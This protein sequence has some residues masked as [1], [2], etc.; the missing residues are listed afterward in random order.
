MNTADKQRQLEQ[1]NSKSAMLE[2]SALIA[3]ETGDFRNGL[4][5]E[6]RYIDCQRRIYQLEHE[7]QL[8]NHVEAA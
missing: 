8:T 6:R 7:L 2:R 4:Y 1:L 5:Y 3:Y